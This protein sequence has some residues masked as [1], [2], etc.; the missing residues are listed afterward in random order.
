MN[1]TAHYQID[2]EN[3]N[4]VYLGVGP[5]DVNTVTALS[6]ARQG[7]AMLQSKKMNLQGPIFNVDDLYKLITQAGEFL[8]N[9]PT[10]ELQ[11]E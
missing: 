8:R 9:L 1:K 6:R 10:A 2:A 3:G 5:N 4:L 11:K 7:L